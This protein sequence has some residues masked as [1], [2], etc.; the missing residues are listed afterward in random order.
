ME[1]SEGSK[2]LEKR[3]QR[4]NKKRSQK[5]DPKDPFQEGEA[6]DSLDFLR[7]ERVGSGAKGGDGWGVDSELGR[8][9][10]GGE[11]QIHSEDGWRRS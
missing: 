3:K 7:T 4:R 9:P 6:R 11:N 5:F 8:R 1:G 2:A 10:W